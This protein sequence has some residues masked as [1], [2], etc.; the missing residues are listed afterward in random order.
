MESLIKAS[1]AELRT[2]YT[3]KT[4]A[5]EKDLTDLKA[6]LKMDTEQVGDLNERVLAM[7]KESKNVSRDFKD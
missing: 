7:E 5:I 3:T 6:N 2:D 4:S 1:S